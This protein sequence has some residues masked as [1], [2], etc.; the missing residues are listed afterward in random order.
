[1]ITRRKILSGIAA[2]AIATPVAADMR[3]FPQLFPW[4]RTCEVGIPIK[5]FFKAQQCEQWC[6]AACIQTVFKLNGFSVTQRNI[7]KRVYGEPP[8]CQPATGPTIKQAVDGKWRD[9]NNNRFRARLNVVFD[10]QYGITHTNA[11]SVVW[12]ELQAGRPLI[13][14][15]NGHAV[16]ITALRYTERTGYPTHTDGVLVRD[17]WP[18]SQ[19]RRLLSPQEFFG[20]AYLATIRI[21]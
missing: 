4:Q 6:W 16:V 20:A 9:A 10:L 8:A 17:P 2:S 7:A 1:M 14:G 21:G 12:S 3:C 15:T 18:Y 5:Q 13:V 11:M 19:H